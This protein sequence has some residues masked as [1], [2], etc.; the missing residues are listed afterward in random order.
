MYVCW[1]HSKVLRLEHYKGLL[2]LGRLA[3]IGCFLLAG[4]SCNQFTTDDLERQTC[5]QSSGTLPWCI[6]THREWFGSIYTVIDRH[7]D[8]RKS[9]SYLSGASGINSRYFG[10]IWVGTTPPLCWGYFAK[11]WP[12][13]RFLVRIP[14]QYC[15]RKLRIYTEYKVV[16][17]RSYC[18]AFT[19]FVSFCRYDAIFDA[20]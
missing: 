1:Y 11:A 20:W 7:P 10:V 3:Q 8:R 12:V 18:C 15:Y 4:P 16:R 6:I 19:Y 13:R 5:E 17:S 14:L 2:L 9:S